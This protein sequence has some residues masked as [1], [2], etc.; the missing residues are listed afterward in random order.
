MKRFVTHKYRC[1]AVHRCWSLNK[2]S[3]KDVPVE[4]VKLCTGE[5]LRGPVAWMLKDKLISCRWNEV[6]CKN[7]LK[8]KGGD[9]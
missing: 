4:Y 6:S 3:F 7:C 9:K 1:I 5:I 2:R 8:F